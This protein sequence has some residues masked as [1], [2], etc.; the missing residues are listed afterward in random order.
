MSTAQ[1]T[2]ATVLEKAIIRP[3]PVDSTSRP[4]WSATT[5]RSA[6]KY[7][8]RNASAASSPRRSKSTAE[9]TRSVNK[10]V[11]KDPSTLGDII[12]AALGARRS[13]LRV[14]LAQPFHP[15]E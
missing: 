6:A 11:T 8:R 10:I 12:A 5:R 14:T 3:S 9:P 7:S 15:P 1:R 13:F 2:A 4:P